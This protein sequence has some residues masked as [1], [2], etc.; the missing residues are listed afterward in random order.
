MKLMELVLLKKFVMFDLDLDPG[1]LLV[2]FLLVEF[3]PSLIWKVKDDP[4]PDSDLKKSLPLNCSTIYLE[5][6]NPSPIPLVFCSWVSW[7]K[8]KS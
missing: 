4:L 5:I 2:R 6:T 7:T 1:M 3:W 8:P